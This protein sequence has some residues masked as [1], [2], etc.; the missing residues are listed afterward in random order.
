[1]SRWGSN[2]ALRQNT[3]IIIAALMAFK[4]YKVSETVVRK[5][6]R[7]L[8]EAKIGRRLGKDEIVHHLDGDAYNVDPTNLVI[9]DRYT[10]Q[11]WHK[12]GA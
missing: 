6:A 11:V 7:M 10:H 1:M 2:G 9:T 3:K 8:V 12:R 4:T 5:Y